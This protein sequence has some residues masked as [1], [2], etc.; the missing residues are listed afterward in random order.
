[1][2]SF[3]LE[4]MISLGSKGNRLWV[5]VSGCF[6]SQRRTL[7]FEITVTSKNELIITKIN[8]YDEIHLRGLFILTVYLTV[9]L[10]KH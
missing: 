5:S 9:Y 8:Q 7:P 1:M 2:L 3:A 6:I 10:Y 4:D